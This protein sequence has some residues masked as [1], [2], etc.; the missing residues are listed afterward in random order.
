MP[1]GPWQIVG[2]DLI[3]GLPPS[4]GIDGNTY[5]AIATYVDLY[6]KQAYFALTTD[7]VDANGIAD[8][9]IRD[10][11]RLHR[12]PRGIIS[13]RGLQFISQFIKALYEKLDI[14]GQ[15]TTAYYPQANRQ[16]EWMNKEIEQYF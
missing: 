10:I 15:L 16:T 13:D 6:L 14:N 9:H 5:I 8:L 1:E 2:T 7:K 12:L 11:F 3:T 4:K